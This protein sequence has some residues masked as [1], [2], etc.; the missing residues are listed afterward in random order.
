MAA[1]IASDIVQQLTGSKVSKA[2]ASAAVSKSL[3]K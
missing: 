2:A 1:D 3:G